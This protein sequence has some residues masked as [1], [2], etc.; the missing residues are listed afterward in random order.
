[1]GLSRMAFTVE[2]VSTKGLKILLIIVCGYI[3]FLVSGVLIHRIGRLV[4]KGKLSD[5]QLAKRAATLGGVLRGVARFAVLFVVG[6]MVLREVGIDPTPILAGAG[7]VGLA[8][9]FGAQ[10]LVK[11]VI[12]GFFILFE[13]HFAVGDIVEIGT[14]KGKIVHVNLRVTQLRDAG[15]NL[16]IIPNSEI[17]KVINSSKDWV[18]AIVD[19]SASCKQDADKVLSVIGDECE[20]FYADK[21]IASKML[22][23]PQVLGIQ[24]FGPSGMTFRIMF[25]TKP[26]TRAE[27]ERAIRLRIKKRFDREKIEMP[28]P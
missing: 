9:G 18:R 21:A 5:T 1:M 19:V 10:N 2:A 11:D 7:I 20:N 14:S 23:K 22:E 24:E 13:N 15:G 16:H 28:F 12:N 17:R 25:K 3:A 6:V 26:V 4:T 27:I 8:V